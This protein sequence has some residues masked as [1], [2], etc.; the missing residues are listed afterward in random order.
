MKSRAAACLRALIGGRCACGLCSPVRRPYRSKR[1]P[2][3]DRCRQKKL[4]CETN[5][6][7]ACQR[8]QAGGVSCSFSRLQVHRGHGSP[9]IPAVVF[10]TPP[11]SQPAF[12]HQGTVTPDYNAEA[13]IPTIE[14][15]P[16]APQEVSYLPDD[17]FPYQFSER[18]T[19]QQAIQTLDLLPGM[20]A[21]VLGTSGESDPF[22]LRHC[23]FDDYGLLHFQH[24]RFRNAGGVP[25]A[26][27]IPVHFLVTDTAVYESARAST[28]VLRQPSPRDVLDSLI[29]VEHGQ[30][31]VALFITHVFPSLPIVPHF[32]ASENLHTIP[33]HLLA[34]LYASALPFAKFDESLSLVYAFQPPPAAQLWRLSLDLILEEIHTPHL[35]VL[36]AGILYLH[37]PHEGPQQSSVADTPF[38]WSFV[39]MMVGT[40]AALGLQFECRPMGMPLWERRLRRRLWWA[41]YSE[42]KWR[43]LLFGRPPYIRLDEWDVTDLDESDFEGAPA[44]RFMRIAKMARI[45]DD[46]QLSLYSL[47]AAQR[48]SPN[49]PDSLQTARV[50]LRQLQE[51]L[52][53]LPPPMQ[54]GTSDRPEL[55]TCVHFAYL[56]LEIFIFRALLRPMVRSAPPPRLI[57]ETEPLPLFPDLTV[58][59]YIAQIID[60]GDIV[61]EE[62]PAVNINEEDKSTPIILNAAENCAAS[63]LRL[64]SQMQAREMSSFWYS[65]CRIGFATVSN[66]M[67][68]LLVQ[69]PTKEHAVRAKKLVYMWQHALQSQ[70]NGWDMM[71]L[72][73][74]RLNGPLSMGLANVFYLPAHLTKIPK[75]TPSGLMIN[76][77]RLWET[78][79]ET[80][81]WGAS[82][83]WGKGETD[84][85]MARLTLTDDDARVRRW[86]AGEVEKL[87]CS[88]SVD[89]MGNMFARQKGKLNSSKPMIAMG[90]HLDTQPRGGRYDGIL[91]VMGAL[92]VLRTMKENGFQTHYDVGI[93]NWTNEEG[94]RFP[95][96]MCSSG[97]WA[98]AISI[99]DSWKLRDIHDQDVTLKSELERHGYLG[100]IPASHEA[101]PLGAHFELHIEQGPILQ[102]TGRSIG[103]VT[104]AQGY[105]WLKFTVTGQ[106]AHTGTTPLSARR[107]P[108]LAAS[109]M[110]VASNEAAK[111]HGALA[112]TGILKIP[113]NS[114]TNTVV[115]NVVFTLD[116]RH[117]E[118]EVVKAV[119]DECLK[120]FAEIAQ[121]DGKG[122]SFEW[123]ND[124]DSPA[125]KFHDDCIDSIKSSAEGLVGP[126]GWMRITSGAGHDTVYT[127]RHCPSAMIFVPCRDGVSHHP[128]EYCTPEDCALGTQTLLE[129]VVHYDQSLLAKQN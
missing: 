113:E 114:S 11:V 87:G 61:G 10:S 94:A 29:P 32:I 17:P 47:R 117:P 126:E 89:Q 110:I 37:K 54:T 2:P 23:K 77:A 46:I 14:P 98:G 66:F 83:R 62:A 35:S 112:S 39:G 92:E 115:S 3:C 122:V 26:E 72:G 7:V 57:D 116:I 68:I 105:R 78:L 19:P 86:F 50:L 101:Y 129:S 28:R 34:A 102:D 118:D 25:L 22:L 60:V 93:V 6:Q 53:L 97:V 79:H 104:G 91:G 52:S 74:V 51:W 12:S 45:G 63:M 43:A 9:A 58:D 88:L 123:T 41:I 48:L 111:R 56:L 65:W 103:V 85:G 69:A 13:A 55:S 109:K 128:T 82:H 106:D 71:D 99:K 70:G 127:S 42:D 119:Q 64:I 8:C 24:V 108:L 95:K 40:A 76:Q 31:L 59:D 73:L 124:T 90:S 84:T 107:D 80:C 27:K 100:G 36:Q 96:S 4:R 121:Q 38:H 20:C 67:M 5:G 33:V 16:I 18:A 120:S 75:V 44:D 81:K 15:D 1:H 49:L 30:R 125:V 21:H